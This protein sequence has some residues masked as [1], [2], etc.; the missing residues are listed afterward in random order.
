MAGTVRAALLAD[1]PD[2]S[3]QFGIDPLP[4]LRKAGLD[5]AVIANPGLNVPAAQ[6]ADLLELAAQ[7]SNREDF[8][9]QLAMRRN[10]AHLGP[11]GLVISQQ[12]SLRH[13]LAMAERYR[14]LLNEVLYVGIE[15]GDGQVL[16]RC[17]LAL[18][19]AM[20]ARQM[21]EL[22]LA[23]TVQL[24]RIVI[25]P[26]WSPEAAL[27]V[28]PAPRD[29]LTHRRFFGCPVRF[30]E[31]CNGLILPAAD[32]DRE[33]PRAQTQLAQQARLLLDSLPPPARRDMLHALRSNLIL[34]LPIGRASARSASKA[35]GLSLRSLQRALDQRGTSFTAE[36]ESLRRELAQRYLAD[37]VLSVG[38]IAHQ[39]G[40]G[41]A[42][43]F[44]R[45]FKGTFGTTPQAWRSAKD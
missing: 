11:S 14:H 41:A 27:L 31:H 37:P 33:N 16:L 29:S 32:L 15:P 18:E 19:G 26:H 1:F 5:L 13:A 6:V 25:D 34:L 35:M 30:G 20:L 21:S 12:P 9:L 28:H 38:E 42:P 8:A 3:R 23:T 7:A 10:L 17:S 44:I 24:A 45:W 4:L 2:L 39:L 40:Y 36:L 43:A 22:A